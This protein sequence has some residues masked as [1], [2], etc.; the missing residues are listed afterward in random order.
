MNAGFLEKH[1]WF[2]TTE[3]TPQGGCISPALANWTLDGLQRLLAEHFAKTLAPFNNGL[4][5]AIIEADGHA[6][7]RSGN[8]LGGDCHGTLL[9]GSSRASRGGR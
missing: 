9:D 7:K 8:G 6:R 2:A 1:A 4:Q 3:G 5:T